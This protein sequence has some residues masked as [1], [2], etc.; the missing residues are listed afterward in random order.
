MLE[1]R[2]M[3]TSIGLKHAYFHILIA[4]RSRKY[5][6]F[7]IGDKV[8]QFRVLPF[9]LLTAPLVFTRVMNMVAAHAHIEG[10][11]VHMYLDDRLLPQLYAERSY[12][13]THSGF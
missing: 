5:L 10:I 7:V 8:Y 13:V 1:S 11:R 3:T 12:C 6:C 2:G 9:G 4:K